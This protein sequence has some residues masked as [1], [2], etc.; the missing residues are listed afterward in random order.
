MLTF[1]NLLTS[2]DGVAISCGTVDSALI[3]DSDAHSFRVSLAGVSC[4]AQDVTLTLTGVHDDQGN[5]LASA[6]VTMSLLL[7]DINGDG[8]VDTADSH[9]VK[10]DRG[11]D[12]NSA[13]FR[14]D[15]NTTGRIDA[16]DFAIV[17]SQL[18]DGLS[19]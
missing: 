1:N 3:D 9:Q 5:T 16:V 12:T 18:G 14:E 13:N 17:K 11:Q 19:Q 8:T 15:M 7:G 4:N 6:S 10:L 2:V